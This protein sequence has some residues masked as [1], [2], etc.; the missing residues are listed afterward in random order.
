M[1]IYNLII[2]KAVNLLTMI[3]IVHR[4]AT[5]TS[6][7]KVTFLFIIEM[8]ILFYPS[9]SLQDIYALPLQFSS[10]LRIF[11]SSF[12]PHFVLFLLKVQEF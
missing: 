7:L 5:K 2:A 1:Y 6:K 9:G 12:G 10:G 11:L 4:F 8:C 3:I